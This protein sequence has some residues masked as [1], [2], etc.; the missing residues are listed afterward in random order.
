MKKIYFVLTAASMFLVALV[1]FG[2]A[3][4]N[5]SFFI[6]GASATATATTTVTYI[7]KG[8]ATTTLACDAYSA[9]TS[10]CGNGSGQVGDGAALLV[11]FTASSTS[12]VLNIA[13]ER[14][15]DNIDWYQDEIFTQT[16]IAT[17][18]SGFSIGSP[19]TYTWTFSS[20][21]IG[22][23]A[24]IASTSVTKI[25]QIPTN[26]RYTRAVFTTTGANGAIWAQ[27]VPKRQQAQ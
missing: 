22:G 16:N 13:V 26:T 10:P 23:N 14:S 7:P 19:L 18:T 5:P 21:T 1:T 27:W 11:R 25:L 12:S 3:H 6:S 24:D 15:M 4:A 2:V 8:T 20:S 17:S 9:I